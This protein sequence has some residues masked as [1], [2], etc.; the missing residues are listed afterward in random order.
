M[1]SLMRYAR[2]L[3]QRRTTAFYLSPGAEHGTGAPARHVFSG[4]R[5]RSLRELF[6][7][8]E[9]EPDDTDVAEDPHPNDD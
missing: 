8:A 7:E 6:S 2:Q 5:Q 1:R 9:Y 3:G 4:G